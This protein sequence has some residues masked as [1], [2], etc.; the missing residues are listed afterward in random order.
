MWHR[1]T[2]SPALPSWHTFAMRLYLEGGGAPPGW[3]GGMGTDSRTSQ[4]LTG[5]LTMVGF[6]SMKKLFFEKRF[7]WSTKYGGR[8]STEKRR[9]PIL[10]VSSTVAPS[11]LCMMTA[12]GTCGM[13]LRSMLSWNSGVA[14]RSSPSSRNGTSSTTSSAAALAFPVP[15]SV[16]TR[17]LPWKHLVMIEGFFR[18]PPVRSRCSAL[19][20]QLLKSMGSDC[21]SIRKRFWLARMTCCMN[22]CGLTWPLKAR[23]FQ[24][25]RISSPNAFTSLLLQSW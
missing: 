15:A 9:R 18:L 17:S 23:G 11:Y 1:Y 5:K 2:P 13:A 3:V 25:L 14:G 7:M 8:R 4:F 10:T 12:S 19:S 20:S 6:F 16:V 24:I 21:A 22:S